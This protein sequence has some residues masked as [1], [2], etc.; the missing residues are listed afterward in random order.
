MQNDDL[1]LLGGSLD[2]PPG[3]LN[4]AGSHGIPDPRNLFQDRPNTVH[5]ADYGIPDLHMPE[6]SGEDLARAP[7]TVVAEFAPDPLLPD[8]L[9]GPLPFALDLHRDPLHD[10]ELLSASMPAE[11]DLALQGWPGLGFEQL[12]VTH[13]ILAPDPLLPDLQQPEIEQ[14]VTMPA[15]ERPGDL[16]PDA[17]AVMHQSLRYQQIA[18]KDYPEV[19]MDQRGTNDRRSREFTLLMKGLDAE[20]QGREL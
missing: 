2:L 14:Q 20:E 18:D 4:L 3:D 11:G 17:L 9:A 6:L 5:Q 8:P 10:D 12:R 16:A 7:L 1:H 19:F 13:D 15:E